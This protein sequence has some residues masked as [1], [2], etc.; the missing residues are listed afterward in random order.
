[1]KLADHSENLTAFR[2]SADTQ[3]R[4]STMATIDLL[5]PV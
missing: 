1:M 4:Q 2:F 5:S 3:E